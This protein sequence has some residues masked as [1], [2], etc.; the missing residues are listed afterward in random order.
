MSGAASIF[1]PKVALGATTSRMWSDIEDLRQIQNFDDTHYHYTTDQLL[2]NAH[3]TH[4]IK[5]AIVCP[6][7][8]YG[9]G[10]GIKRF[11]MGV[12]WLV[13]AIKKR[14]KS[15]TVNGGGNRSSGSHVKDVADVLVMFAEEAL[16]PENKRLT[17]GKDGFYF[18][19]SGGYVLS[20][21]TAAAAKLMAE[22][23]MIETEEI[24]ALSPDEVIK[25]HPWGPILWGSNM[26]VTASRLRALGWEPK[27]PDAFECL[28]EIFV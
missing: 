15:F 2:F 16:L 17:W 19:E 22:K 14:G 25:I 3:Q 13:D 28:P 8:V 23:G 6:S 7:V 10:E 27:H 21:I 12:P 4:G 1:D 20:E 24:D 9:A 26:G 5:S 11:S 18:I